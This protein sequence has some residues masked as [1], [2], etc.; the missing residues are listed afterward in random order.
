MVRNKAF[1]ETLTNTVASTMGNV[2]QRMSD[3]DRLLKMIQKQVADPQGDFLTELKSN[4][5]RE[6]IKPQI[7]QGV[8][9]KLSHDDRFLSGLVHQPQVNQHFSNLKDYL[10][11]HFPA[12]GKES[13]VNALL[14]NP[15]PERWLDTTEGWK[16]YIIIRNKGS[17]ILGNTG[18]VFKRR[19][20]NKA[21]CA[22]VLYEF[23]AV[24][25]PISDTHIIVGLEKET[26]PDVDID[27]VN[28]FSSACSSDFFIS[29]LCSEREVKYAELLGSDA[30]LLKEADVNSLLDQIIE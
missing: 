3:P 26:S 22:P 16:W 17:F 28:H 9:E 14:N 7:I 12:Q 4:L 20:A 1:R 2:L 6:Q 29:S 5:K 24:Y 23:E 15:I 13:H 8:L 27:L 18:P 19:N 11:R 30:K 21:A 25:L 10:E